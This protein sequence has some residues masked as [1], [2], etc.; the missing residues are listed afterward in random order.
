[1]TPIDQVSRA[2]SLAFSSPP[3]ASLARDAGPYSFPHVRRRPL[4]S[5]LSAPSYIKG[6][7]RVLTLLGVNMEDGA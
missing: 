6:V 3:V 1:M 7:E 4:Q 2:F 5:P